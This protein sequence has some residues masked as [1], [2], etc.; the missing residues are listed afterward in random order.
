MTTIYPSERKAEE[1]ERLRELR[2][3]LL[4]AYDADDPILDASPSPLV[5]TT[6]LF[7]VPHEMEGSASA[8]LR[9]AAILEWFEDVVQFARQQEWSV[10][11]TRALLL[12]AQ[13]MVEC[14]EGCD[15]ALRRRRREAKAAPPPPP[16]LP[17]PLR[18]GDDDD[19]EEAEAERTAREED[20]AMEQAVSSLLQRLVRQAVFPSTVQVVGR[21]ITPVST[22]HTIPDPEAMEALE[23]KWKLKEGKTLNRKQQQQM[24]EQ[25][26]AVPRRTTT[27]M[28]EKI[29][30]WETPLDFPP[31]WSLEEM[32]RVMSFLTTS[33]LGHW[34]LWCVVLHADPADLPPEEVL[35]LPVPLDSTQRAF[36]PPLKSFFPAS[37]YTQQEERRTIWREVEREKEMLF[38]TGFLPPL[39]EMAKKVKAQMEE[40]RMDWVEKERENDALKLSGA[41]YERVHHAFVLR[42]AKRMAYNAEVGRKAG[43]IRFAEEMQAI[44]EVMKEEA[45]AAEAAA[46][47][48]LR[49]EAAAQ[50]R[51]GKKGR[52][53]RG[54]SVVGFAGAAAAAAAKKS[55][56]EKGSTSMKPTPTTAAGKRKEAG[57]GRGSSRGGKAAEPFGGFRGHASQNG[58]VGTKNGFFEYD[59]VFDWASVDER[60]DAILTVLQ[61]REEIRKE[62]EQQGLSGGKKRRGSQTR[63]SSSGRK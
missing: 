36:I 49:E 41:E 3:R 11:Q 8:S 46:A 40:W 32:M 25:L 61:R 22:V 57:S 13:S 17:P 24:K 33:V 45:E 10:G 54:P 34:R 2:L 21:T 37:F 23:Q 43:E 38:R 26:D 62:Q 1:M 52:T 53:S 56:K 4:A 20:E 31:C 50:Q 44:S 12:I 7:Y 55:G 35:D 16:H 19:E 5:Y 63:R 48:A 28:E 6:A 30:T 39:Q 27:T 60:L 47:A 14:V 29:T 51:G 15:A 58:G 9:Q 18:T 59:A 42:L